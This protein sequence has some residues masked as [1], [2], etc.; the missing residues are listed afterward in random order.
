MTKPLLREKTVYRF[1]HI[2]TFEVLE[3]DEDEG[4][5]IGTWHEDNAE[6]TDYPLDMVKNKIENKTVEVM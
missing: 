2:G 4:I 6:P 5:V 3:I 1:K